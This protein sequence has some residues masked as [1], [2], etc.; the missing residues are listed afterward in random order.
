MV[1]AMMGLR[2]RRSFWLFPPRPRPAQGHFPPRWAAGRRA[3][4]S[5]RKT[6]SGRRRSASAPCPPSCPRSTDHGPG[7]GPWL[8]RAGL[9]R[10]GLPA[11]PTAPTRRRTLGTPR[12]RPLLLVLPGGLPFRWPGLPFPSPARD[13]REPGGRRSPCGAAVPSAGGGPPR[14]CGGRS[15]PGCTIVKIPAAAPYPPPA[16]RP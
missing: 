12:R 8:R 11:A 6:A 7:A 2:R 13:R 16:P 3:R 9:R 14:G 10:A 15:L 5:A 4:V 1:V